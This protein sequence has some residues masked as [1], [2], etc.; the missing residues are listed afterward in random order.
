MSVEVVPAELCTTLL[1]AT[2]MT[3]MIGVVI[4]GVLGF[5]MTVIISIYYEHARNKVL[6]LEKEVSELKTEI[7][8]L[9]EGK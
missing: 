7:K 3:G 6:E 2:G 9:R 1:K 5:F 8:I 4:I